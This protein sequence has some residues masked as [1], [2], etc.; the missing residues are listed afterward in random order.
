MQNARHPWLL[1]LA[2]LSRDDLAA[3]GAKNLSIGLLSRLGLSTPPGFALSTEAFSQHLRDAGV[4]LSAGAESELDRRRIQETPLGTAACEA[5]AEAA[6]ALLAAGHH[7]AARSSLYPFED[8]PRHAC[9]GLFVSRLNLASARAIEA[10]VVEC[11]ASLWHE[12]A[13]AYFQFH[14]LDRSLARMSVGLQA[15]VDAVASATV[16]TQDPITH[17]ERVLYL[18]AAHGFGGVTNSALVETDSFF[19]EKGEAPRIISRRKGTKRR[20]LVRKPQG[21]LDLVPN[22]SMGF[23]LEDDVLLRIA[24][25]AARIEAAIGAPQDVELAVTAQGEIIY[26][27]SRGVL[28][29]TRTVTDIRV[30]ADGVAP[31]VTGTS[32]VFGAATAPLKIHHDTSR[33]ADAIILKAD[34]AV[35]DVPKMYGAR[36]LI[37]RDI[38]PTS[39]PAIH[40]R[41]MG[42]PTLSVGERFAELTEQ[43]GAV[44]T[45]DTSGEQ[46]ALLPGARPVRR[47]E[48]SGGALPATPVGVHLLT[49]YPSPRWS[50]FLRD[51]PIEGVHVR[52]ESVNNDD[53]RTHPL[54]LLAYDED[55]LEGAERYLIERRI[56]GYLDGASFYVS[57]FVERLG[58][59]R[60]ALR[61]EQ[62]ICLRL[63]D[64]MTSDYRRLIGGA[65]FEDNE[66]N[67]VLGMRGAA[68][69]LHPR[70][71]RVL[72]L[73]LTALAQAAER[74]PGRYEVL[75]PVVRTPD[76]MRA[77]RAIMAS[78]GLAL[79][80]G[81]MVETPAAVL[82]APRF[83]PLADFFCIG[84]ADLTQFINGADRTLHDMVGYTNPLCEATRAAVMTLMT[85]LAGHN[86][87]VH[88]TESLYLAMAPWDELAPNDHIKVVTWP[89]RLLK[90]LQNLST[91][92]KA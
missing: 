4:S 5:I 6:E 90:T 79:P 57:K 88:M 11:F 74:F 83:V 17:N 86:K 48:F 55:R 28:P 69:L 91:R 2:S 12:S 20:R 30:D 22:T 50:S 34:L 18:D 71:R 19:L 33:N 41:E 47:E 89:D 80:L 43:V 8:D 65:L 23:A 66:E 82:L 21:G 78:L 59:L 9:A 81:M 92:P 62:S 40:L 56:A 63:T 73:E 16:F 49:T 64:L 14:G 3:V 29:A 10:A 84:A 31:L 61:P 51:S 36:G 45:L 85:A 53:I 75:V 87:D 37:V 67:P 44:V 52:G 39:H 68:R 13:V 38:P 27:Q 77:I 24:R 15:T 76:E 7:V 42:V 1:P 72:E 26:L 25:D 58:L 60:A 32:V 54:A 46:G 70:F 35:R